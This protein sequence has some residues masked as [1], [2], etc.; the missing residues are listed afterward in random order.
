MPIPSLHHAPTGRSILTPESLSHLL[1]IL[2]EKGVSYWWDGP[3]SEFVPP[4][5]LVDGENTEE[6]WTKGTC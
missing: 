5:Y 2:D 6:T 3:V 4:E 1:S